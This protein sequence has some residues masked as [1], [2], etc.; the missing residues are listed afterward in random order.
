MRMRLCLALTLGVV[1]PSPAQLAADALVV[2]GVMSFTSLRDLTFGTVLRGVSTTVA[3]TAATAGAWQAAGTANAFVTIS[4]ALPTELVNI[5]AAPGSTM[6]IAFLG[7]SGRWRRANNDPNGATAFDPNVGATGRFG[8]P[9]NPTLYIWLGGQVSPA[10]NAKPGI[11]TG[12]V[13]A[14]LVYP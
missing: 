8:P 6:P 10:A 4:F 5:Q 14:T 1:A 7:T 13:V 11:Y 2:S 3:P 9:P 12:T